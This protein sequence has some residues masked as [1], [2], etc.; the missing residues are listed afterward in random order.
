MQDDETATIRFD[1]RRV[2]TAAAMGIATV[3]AASLV[4]A[5]TSLASTSEA[6]RPF[7]AQ[8]PEADLMDLRRRLEATRRPGKEHVADLRFWT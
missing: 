1:R 6:I 2:L 7:R 4:P 8:I 3:G 5:L